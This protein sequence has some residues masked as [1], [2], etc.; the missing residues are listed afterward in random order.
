MGHLV[1]SISNGKALRYTDA[2]RYFGRSAELL[3][4]NEEMYKHWAELEIERRE[5]TAAANAAERGLQVLENS[6]ILAH[7]AGLHEANLGGTE[8]S[9]FVESC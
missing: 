6:S 4:T 2:Q 8:S 3:S 7:K 9:G 1:G 5:W